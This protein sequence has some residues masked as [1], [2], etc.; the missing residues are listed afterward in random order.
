[1]TS[2]LTAAKFDASKFVARGARIN[3]LTG[4]FLKLFTLASIVTLVLLISKITG[5][6]TIG[7]F[8]V[9][10][11]VLASLA[12]GLFFMVLALVFAAI[13]TRSN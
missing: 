1:M 8:A 5:L 11:P 2:T 10:L 9:F 13:A 3:Y 12:I 7:W 4:V 6:L